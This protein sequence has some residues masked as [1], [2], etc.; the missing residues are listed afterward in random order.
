VTRRAA[1][2][3]AAV[4]LASAPFGAAAQDR[5]RAVSLVEAAIAALGGPRYLSVTSS[6]ATGTFTPFVQGQRGVPL[7]FV[8]TFA[9]PDRNRTE[10]GKK[11]TRVVQSNAGTLG[12][13]YDG[14]RQ[15][16]E[17]QGEEEIR[18]FQ[19]F[20]RA[21]LDNILRGGWRQE[22]VKLHHITRIEIAPRSWA[23]GVAVE[24][25]DGLRVEM[26][27]DPLTH[28][29][30]LTRYNDGAES[31]APG[32][33]LETRYHLY[34]DFGGVMAPRT[35]DLYRDKLQTARIVYDDIKFNVPVDPKL[36]DQP[37]NAKDLK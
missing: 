15:I 33:Q 2:V 12:W 36:F 28:L 29:P 22:G 17:A 10:F 24:Y 9:Y 3:A 1:L 6:V 27:F 34:L 37:A 21:N 35:V 26:F 25:P 4:L 13:K 11:K 14:A 23:E 30:V 32:S 16:V 5:D 7:Q 20:V 8:D 19:R 18:A 31:G